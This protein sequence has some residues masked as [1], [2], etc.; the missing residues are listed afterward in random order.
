MNFPLNIYKEG[1]T[2]MMIV[3]PQ[4]SKLRQRLLPQ[5]LMVQQW[6]HLFPHSR[7]FLIA[8]RLPREPRQM[9]RQRGNAIIAVIPLLATTPQ[10]QCCTSSGSRGNKISGAAL[11]K[12]PPCLVVAT[13][14]CT[15][16]EIPHRCL[17]M[18]YH[19]LERECWGNATR[20]L[21]RL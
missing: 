6:W 15:R 8:R 17:K 7:V 11:L 21:L 5:G 20:G 3:S 18:K 4:P 9:E 14:S 13:R 2:M 1:I 12:S 19:C 10:R 16:S